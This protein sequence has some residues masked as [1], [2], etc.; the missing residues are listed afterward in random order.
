MPVLIEEL[1]RIHQ[2]QGLVARAERLCGIEALWQGE[3]T[4]LPE[5]EEERDSLLEVSLGQL[6]LLLEEIRLESGSGAIPPQAGSQ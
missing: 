4:G 3:D 1:H 6:D 5:S 2:Q